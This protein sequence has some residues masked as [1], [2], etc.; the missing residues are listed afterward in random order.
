MSPNQTRRLPGIKAGL[1]CWNNA[2]SGVDTDADIHPTSTARP[3]DRLPHIRIG[4]SQ[5]R[6]RP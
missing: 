5:E 6:H 1:T 4:F 3:G 2:I